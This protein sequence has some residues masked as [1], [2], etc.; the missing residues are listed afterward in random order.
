Q[1]YGVTNASGL[2]PTHQFEFLYNSEKVGS[3]SF[4][5]IDLHQFRAEIPA[6]VISETPQR[7]A[8]R[9]P[10]GRMDVVDSITL[11]WIEARYPSR[12][13]GSNVEF[14]TF[15]NDFIDKNNRPNE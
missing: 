9:T 11:D 6:E 14:Y 5:G 4:D 15:N 13:D 8:F 7:F 12:F 3:S 10:P 2:K 1:V